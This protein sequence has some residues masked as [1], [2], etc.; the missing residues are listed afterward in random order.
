MEAMEGHG[1]RTVQDW[2]LVKKEP[3]WISMELHGE[4]PEK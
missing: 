3:P 4:R 2:W 1:E